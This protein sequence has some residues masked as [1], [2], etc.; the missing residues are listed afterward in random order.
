MRN[1][2]KTLFTILNSLGTLFYVLGFI[3]LVPLIFVLV[4]NETINGYQTFYAFLYPS[5]LSF[6][7]GLLSKSIFKAGSPSNFQAMIICSLGWIFFSAIG[8]LVFVIGIKASFLDG[9]FE[10]MSGFTTTGITMFTGLDQMPK[11]VLFWRSLTQWVGGLGILTFILAVT[12]LHSASH[13]LYGAEGHKI[14]IRRPVPGLAHTI[15]IFWFIYTGLTCFIIVLLSITG[16]S[17]FDSVCHSLTALSTGGFSPHDASIEY[18]RLQGFQHYRIMEYIII[19]G[20]FF[21]G[22]NFLIHYHFLNRNFQAIKQN[23]EIRYWISFI[24]LFCIL[25]LLERIVKNNSFKGVIFGSRAFWLELENNIRLTLF[26]VVSILTTTGFGTKDIN[27]S[28]FGPLAKQ[29][30]LIMMF[31]GGCVGSTGGGFK[32]LRVGILH[33]LIN[34]EITLL[35]SSKKRVTK[36]RVNN[37]GIEDNEIYRIGALFFIWIFLIIA[38][39]VITILFSKYDAWSS[40]SGMFSAL[41]NIGPCYIP[42]QEL[43]LLHPIIKIV[44]IFGM[45]AGRLEI[46]PVLLLFSFRAWRS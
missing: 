44:Y 43:G 16:M 25:I 1:R 17:I 5:I 14:N 13:Q 10:T 38:G 7:L 32:I 22:T 19:L 6:V 11:S 36:I 12:S 3:L 18:Y 20:M 23:T 9:F 29:L 35:F 46:L 33:K 40:L 8:S 21:G 15:K 31:I 2:L 24:L 26:Q 39:G 27:T 30:F 42:V 4:D 45:L 28:F 34:R 37:K 41:G